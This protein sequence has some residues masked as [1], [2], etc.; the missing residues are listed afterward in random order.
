MSRHS[1]RNTSLAFFTAYERSLLDYGT[2][3]Q[4]LGRDS[5]RSFDACHLCLSRAR[6]PVA[7]S[8]NGD[9]F[10]RECAM[11]NILAQLKEIKRMEKEMAENTRHEEDTKF[12]EEEQARALAIKEFELIQMGLNTT[13]G[14]NRTMAVRK[15]ETTVEKKPEDSE[16]RGVKRSFVL[17][18]EDLLR[19]A[20]AS[21]P[22]L[23]S[24]WLPSLTP[25]AE[26]KGPQGPKTLNPVC[27]ASNRDE[28]HQISLKALIGVKF[29]EDSNAMT[30]EG[31][32]Q[33]IC[34]ACQKVLTNALKACMMK[35]CGHVICSPCVDRFVK[36][37]L[38]C[39]I[40]EEDVSPK[41]V[42][43]K[44]KI[45]RGII[46]MKSEGTGFAKGGNAE[47]TKVGV[48]FQGG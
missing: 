18:E 47:V 45:G 33:R 17:D 42:S 38:R 26:G 39:Y 2:K 9:I 41:T 13:V 29:S 35:P 46:E 11:E 12:Y 25:N 8:T 36:V 1:K 48:A 40:C 5:F 3:K 19:V 27:P 16:K 34:P 32:P 44:D 6:D 4:R 20:A 37:T 7:C 10:C 22:L 43:K 28:A 24:F 30:K 31:H 21:K 23:P 15:G 14:S